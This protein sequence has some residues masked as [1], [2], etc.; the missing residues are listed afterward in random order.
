MSPAVKL[1]ECATWCSLK[2]INSNDF[3]QSTPDWH[4]ET[5]PM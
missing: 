3:I 5:E 1:N 2:K 4:S